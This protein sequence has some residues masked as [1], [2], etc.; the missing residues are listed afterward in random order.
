MKQFKMLTNRCV[1]LILNIGD[2]NFSILSSFLLIITATLIEIITVFTLDKK[3]NELNLL[4]LI[5]FISFTV[6]VILYFLSR[7]I[8]KVEQSRQSLSRLIDQFEIMR[9]RDFFHQDALKKINRDQDRFISTISH[10]L[11]TPL[12]GIVG[13]SHILLDTE[14]NPDRTQYLRTIYINAFTLIHIFNDI[15]NINK[16]ERAEMVLD[17]QEISLTDFCVELEHISNLLA[18]SKGLEFKIK[19]SPDLPKKVIIDGTRLRQILWNLIG[20]AAKFS[21]QGKII[22]NVSY[23]SENRLIFCVKDPGIGISIEEQDKI[24]TLYYQIKNTPGKTANKGAGI[25]LAVS[26]QFAQKMGGDI[27]VKSMK[28]QGSCFTLS[29]KAPLCLENTAVLKNEDI[30]LPLLHVLL[31]EDVDINITVACA[32]FKKL[33]ISFEVAMSG[34][35]ALSIFSPERFDLVFLDIHLPDMTGFEIAQQIRSDHHQ[36]SLPPLIAFT[37]N[38]LKKEKEYL[39]KGMN[40]VL[41]KPLSTQSLIQIIRKYFSDFSPPHPERKQQYRDIEDKGSV[42]NLTLLK[43][44]IELLGFP[45]MKKNVALFE[46][47]LPHYLATLEDHAK[48]KN[49]QGILEE[50]HKIESACG[51]VGLSYLQQ[52]CHEIQTT[53]QWNKIQYGV[54]DL[55]Q[56]WK[57]HIKMLREWIEQNGERMQ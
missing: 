14:L 55:K 38:I 10:E 37:A 16:I 23:E 51:S 15:M 4:R 20:N 5:F 48:T 21:D 7:V 52:C 41:S 47:T 18:Y 9:S 6:V 17:E 22:V 25:G 26:K 39:E 42:F 56:H 8:K 12:S 34:S 30:N 28:G 54:D 35:E 45:T 44:Y 32:V 33:K 57:S 29:V 27:T 2:F 13:L 1:H 31:V 53:S 36:K 46:K 19:L 43:H 3:M 24:F 49:Q 50:A 40:E 11:L